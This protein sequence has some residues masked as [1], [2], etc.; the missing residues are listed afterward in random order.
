M[1]SKII[2]CIYSPSSENIKYEYSNK[3]IIYPS[4]NWAIFLRDRPL[5]IWLFEKSWLEYNSFRPWSNICILSL[6]IKN[7]LPL[8][9]KNVNGNL[10]LIANEFIY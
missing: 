10:P 7:I 1:F 8:D 9:I 6:V 3:A 5:S 4:E 2:S